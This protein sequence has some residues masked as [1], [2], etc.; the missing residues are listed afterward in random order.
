MFVDRWPHLIGHRYIDTK[1]KNIGACH[2][3]H[4]TGLTHSEILHVN[5]VI[6]KTHGDNG[7]MILRLDIIIFLYED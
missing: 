3:I 5:K 7:V 1:V 2:I 4:G 6:R